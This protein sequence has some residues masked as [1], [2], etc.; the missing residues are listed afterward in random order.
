M[1]I[2]DL[3]VLPFGLRTSAQLKKEMPTANGY[4][5]FYVMEE[6]PD[7]V[8]LGADDFHLDFRLSIMRH[9]SD[10]NTELLITTAVRVHNLLGRGYI[11]LIRP[12]HHLLVRRT[13]LRLVR[14]LTLRQGA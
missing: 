5:F 12:F 4:G 1:T 9:T 6:F 14:M 13:L 8:V 7:E 11:Q 2:R 10:A 3:V